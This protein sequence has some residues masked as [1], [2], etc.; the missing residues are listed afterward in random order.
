[1]LHLKAQLLQLRLL[2]PIAA[3]PILRLLDK[4]GVHLFRRSS[5]VR[6]RYIII[7]IQILPSRSINQATKDD[8]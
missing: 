1:M 8:K 3:L 2:H 5:P 4:Q 6:F 7:S